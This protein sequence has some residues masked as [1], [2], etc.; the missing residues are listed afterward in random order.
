MKF[1]LWQ[2][3]LCAFDEVIISLKCSLFVADCS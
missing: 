2:D 3:L 1:S